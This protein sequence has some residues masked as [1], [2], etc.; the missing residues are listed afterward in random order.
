M[1]FD[2]KLSKATGCFGYEG[3]MGI[4]SYDTGVE[5]AGMTPMKNKFSWM[6]M[7]QDETMRAVK[8]KGTSAQSERNEKY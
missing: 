7:S 3:S 2:K 8:G 5:K 4:P 6:E 1:R